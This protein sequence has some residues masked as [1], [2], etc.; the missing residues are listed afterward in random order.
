MNA[1][2][3][4]ESDHADHLRAIFI[5]PL[6]IFQY[7]CNHLDRCEFYPN[8]CNHDPDCLCHVK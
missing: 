6:A 8:E 7:R 5:W 4:I 1:G 3:G 2:R